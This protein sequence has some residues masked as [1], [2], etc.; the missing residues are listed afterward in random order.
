VIVNRDLARYAVERAQ[1][2]G[3]PYQFKRPGVGG[4]DASAIQRAAAGVAVLPISVPVRYIHSPASVMSL[5]DMRLTTDLTEDIIREITPQ[6]I[7]G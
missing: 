7:K 5:K 4:T 3:I 2:R 6:L 1:K